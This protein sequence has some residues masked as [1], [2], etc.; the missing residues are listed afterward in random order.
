MELC[1]SAFTIKPEEMISSHI[2]GGLGNMLFQLA[3]GKSHSLTTNQ[4]YK[5]SYDN[6]SYMKHSPFSEY[7]SNIFKGIEVGNVD[8]IKTTHKEPS[9]RY[10]PIPD[11]K[12]IILDGYYQS[13]KPFWAV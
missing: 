1:R 11:I 5:V 3:A 2:M 4:T 7:E 6:M 13:E 10:H 8:H 9:F 12:D